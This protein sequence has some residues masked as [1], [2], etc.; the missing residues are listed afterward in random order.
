ESFGH[1]LRGLLEIGEFVGSAEHD[2][3]QPKIAALRGR[4]DIESRLIV[5]SGL[6]TVASRI[7]ANKV[8]GVAQLKRAAAKRRCVNRGPS[9]H[10]RIFEQFA[11]E[12][13]LVISARDVRLLAGRGW[14]AVNGIVV[15][16]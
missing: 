7:G 5:K 14:E 16:V 8:V 1:Q 11:G 6:Q 15:S 13:R 9:N 2:G 4:H 10:V 3:Y 12:Q